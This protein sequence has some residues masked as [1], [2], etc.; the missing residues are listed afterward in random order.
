MAFICIQFGFGIRLFLFLFSF[1]LSSPSL[2]SF[3]LAFYCHFTLLLQQQQPATT[4]TTTTTTIIDNNN[5][6]NNTRMPRAYL[7]C[8]VACEVELAAIPFPI[9]PPTLYSIPLSPSTGKPHRNK[10][11]AV[12]VAVEV[13]GPAGPAE[14]VVP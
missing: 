7:C 13:R 14:P 4:T 9:P 10:R 8:H 6:N 5:S 1:S 12:A 2:Y 3:L 11:A